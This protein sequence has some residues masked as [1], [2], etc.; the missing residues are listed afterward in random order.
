V[1]I[2]SGTKQRVAE[3]LWPTFVDN[4]RAIVYERWNVHS[5]ERSKSSKSDLWLLELREGAQPKKIIANAASPAGQTLRKAQSTKTGI[6]TQPSPTSA[7]T[8]APLSE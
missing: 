3:G 7:G 8:A 1:D 4:G 5:I 6:N 2:D